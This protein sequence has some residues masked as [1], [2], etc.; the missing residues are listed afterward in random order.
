M[1]AALLRSSLR[2]W[3]D[4]APIPPPALVA[5]VRG[6]AMYIAGSAGT[7]PTVRRMHKV[8][9]WV[10]RCQN[11]AEHAVSDC[12]P[13]ASGHRQRHRPGSGPLRHPVVA[14][15]RSGSDA[16]RILRRRHDGGASLAGRHLRL[17]P[18][19]CERRSECAGERRR[20]DDPDAPPPKWLETIDRLAPIPAL[21][22]GFLLVI[23]SPNLWVFTLSAIATIADAGLDRSDSIIAFLVFLRSLPR[24]CLLRERSQD[25]RRGRRSPLPQQER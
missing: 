4:S 7:R 23:T 13:A 8:G 12:Q 2:A 21:G 17:H 5:C 1:V 14:F 9:K 11:G 3:C 18:D 6:A 20:G 16:R 24:R 25:D 19:E 22:L 10:R 15:A